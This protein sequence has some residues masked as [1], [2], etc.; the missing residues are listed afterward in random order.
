MRYMAPEVVESLPYNE[1]VDV[2]A[3]GLLLWEMLQYR[4]VF[5]GMSVGEFYE[6]VVNGGSRP[7]LDSAWPV[8]LRKLISLCWHPDVDK[9]PDFHVIST[10]LRAVYQQVCMCFTIESSSVGS[11]LLLQY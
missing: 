6:R 10:R 2:Y 9:R 7:P 1:K 5:E 3:F 8:E 11:C 4:R